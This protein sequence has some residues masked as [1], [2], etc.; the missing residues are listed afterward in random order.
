MANFKTENRQKL[1]LTP[2]LHPY[3]EYK[4]LDP[5]NNRTKINAASK[6]T[7]GVYVFK[8]VVTK[9]CYVGSGGTKIT[10][11]KSRVCSYFKP[12]NLK[13]GTRKVLVY[14]NKNG[15]KNIELKLFI[16]SPTSSWLERLELEQYFIN[17]LKP[18]L[19]VSSKAGGYM[20]II[21]L[22]QKKVVLNYEKK[23]VTLFTCTIYII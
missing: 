3:K 9:D 22:C 20:V 18:N 19:N 1:N 2:V 13:T 6:K 11:L 14:F 10:D 16:M 21:V 17:T 23:E 5:F 8:N 12:Y 7:I 15:F 4:I